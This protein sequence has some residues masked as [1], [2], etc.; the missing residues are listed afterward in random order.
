MLARELCQIASQVLLAVPGV[1]ITPEIPK[2]SP[3]KR[4]QLIVTDFP[5]EGLL[6]GSNVI[7]KKR[8]VQDAEKDTCGNGEKRVQ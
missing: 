8:W 1:V 7:K 5:S 3:P 6:T 4:P 2:K